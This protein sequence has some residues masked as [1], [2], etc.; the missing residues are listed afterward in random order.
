MAYNNKKKPSKKDL[1]EHIKFLDTKLNASYNNTK[2][3]LDTI[4]ALLNDYITFKGD[5][6]SFEKYLQD[7]YPEAMNKDK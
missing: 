7:R 5:F 6:D 4:N 3:Y 2:A 1:L